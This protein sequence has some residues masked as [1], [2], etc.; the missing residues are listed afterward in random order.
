MQG[1]VEPKTE[2][3]PLCSY[4]HFRQGC[5][6]FP[7]DEKIPTMPIDDEV[8]EYLG[9]K[10]QES[11]IKSQIRSLREVLVAAVTNG[12]RDGKKI[13]VGDHLVSLRPK[14]K[15]AVDPDRLKIGYPDLFEK[16]KK[17]SSWEEII[18]D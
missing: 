1:R 11:E 7:L 17:V 5:S 13:R 18:I 4:C 6:A 3:G 2:K 12:G 10:A 14:S 16:F 8:G 15:T 9:L